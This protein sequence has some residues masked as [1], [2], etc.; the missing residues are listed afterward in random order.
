MFDGLAIFSIHVLCI[1]H[2]LFSAVTT[3]SVDNN[4]ELAQL[5][6]YYA[7]GTITRIPNVVVNFIF[8]KLC[9][10]SFVICIFKVSNQ[11][12]IEVKV[13]IKYSLCPRE[14]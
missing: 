3:D 5:R 12:Y 7:P 14:T 9:K 11:R 4:T 13:W 6:P 1:W 8:I 10:F 2:W